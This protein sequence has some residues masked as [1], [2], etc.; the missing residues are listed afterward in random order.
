MRCASSSPRRGRTVVGMRSSRWIGLFVSAFIFGCGAS[1]P[2]PHDEWTAAQAD[3]ARAQATGAPNV[4]DAKLHQQLAVEDLN[5]AKQLI[6]NDNKRA[7]TLVSLARAEAQL[8]LSL[9]KST[10]AEAQ[11][12]SIQ[13]DLAKVT[14]GGQAGGH[15]Q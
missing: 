12:R 2:P 14:A 11:T 1:F 10:A 13:D 5:Q 4:P 9:A 3:V 8:A 6:D 15:A 7:T